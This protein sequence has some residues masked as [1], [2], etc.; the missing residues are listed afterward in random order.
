MYTPN[1]EPQD[2]FHL[3]LVLHDIQ[4]LQT[5]V[6]CRAYERGGTRDISYPSTVCTVAQEDES[7]HDKFFWKPKVTTAS[8]SPALQI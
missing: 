1:I 4:L 8:Q 2:F 5:G 3:S 6:V 7:T